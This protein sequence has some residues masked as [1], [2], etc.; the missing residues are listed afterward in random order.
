MARSSGYRPR[1]C[2][3][4]E[5]E[6]LRAQLSATHANEWQKAKC[7]MDEITRVLGHRR[8][9]S[10]AGISPRACVY[11]H[12]YG[13][14]R[15]FCRKLKEDAAK[16]ESM[17]YDREIA[18]LAT[19]LNGRPDAHDEQWEK[20]LLWTRRQYE[21]LGEMGLGCDGPPAEAA[22]DCPGCAGCDAWRAA[23]AAWEAQN[24]PPPC[25][26]GGQPV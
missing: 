19:Y 7:L 24:P 3:R 10:G 2:N 18:L 23:A 13:H 5:V 20:W 4:A 8:G 22:T 17:G 1:N 26:L 14:T 25:V 11:C 15:Q 12:Y 9:P 21:A 16:R 6:A